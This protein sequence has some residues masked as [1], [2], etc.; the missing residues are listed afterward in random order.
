M[1]V[2]THYIFDNLILT[3]CKN[4]PLN[5]APVKQLSFSISINLVVQ[6]INP[7]GW[8]NSF[9]LYIKSLT[10]KNSDASCVM[11]KAHKNKLKQKPMNDR[12]S[13]AGTNVNKTE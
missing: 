9:S 3:A 13:A 2:Y 4:K 10:N 7:W 5:S 12:L 11:L 1:K 8:R 6:V